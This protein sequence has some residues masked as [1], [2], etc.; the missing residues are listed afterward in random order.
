MLGLE[1]CIHAVVDSAGVSAARGLLA[2]RG[3]GR[4]GG[5]K[6]CFTPGEASRYPGTTKLLDHTRQEQGSRSP[7]SVGN[8]REPRFS[9]P[10]APNVSGAE[11]G[12]YLRA[13][14]GRPVDAVFEG[15]L[16]E[17]ADGMP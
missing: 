13:T 10:L 8:V 3:K 16:A 15:V 9:R 7:G 14:S 2:R 12:G 11:P 6:Q 5:G 1:T 17:R 4:G